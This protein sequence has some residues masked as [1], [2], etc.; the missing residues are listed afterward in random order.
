M[1][2]IPNKSNQYAQQAVPD[3]QTAVAGVKFQI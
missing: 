2:K 1:L 3:C